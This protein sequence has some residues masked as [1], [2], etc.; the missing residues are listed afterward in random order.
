MNMLSR[1]DFSLSWRAAGLGRLHWLLLRCREEG[2]RPHK[3]S[4]LASACS[5]GESTTETLRPASPRV[6][7]PLLLQRVVWAPLWLLLPAWSRVTDFVSPAPGRA[8]TSSIAASQMD[9]QTLRWPA[10]AMWPW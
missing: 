10:R 1:F 2:V 8:P 7:P 9:G 4:N 3:G 6:P 5:P